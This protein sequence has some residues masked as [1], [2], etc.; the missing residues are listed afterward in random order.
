VV[1]RH[2]FDAT[3]LFE[4]RLRLRE[5]MELPRVPM[6]IFLGRASSRSLEMLPGVKSINLAELREES[7]ETVCRLN[8]GDSFHM[9]LQNIDRPHELETA[10]LTVGDLSE[11][12]VDEVTLP[13]PG[14]QLL[15]ARIAPDPVREGRLRGTL[16]LVGEPRLRAG[17]TFLKSVA[18]RLESPITLMV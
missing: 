9:V 16:V 18:S 3:S 13:L 10:D 7:L 11:L 6:A 17:A 14:R 8:A 4:G 15:L 1:I 5:V 12:D 2:H